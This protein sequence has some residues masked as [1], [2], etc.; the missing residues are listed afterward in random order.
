MGRIYGAWS[1]IGLQFW[2]EE[3]SWEGFVCDIS[4]GSSSVPPPLAVGSGEFT[5]PSPRV[6]VAGPSS[7]PPP[8][9]VGSGQSTPSPPTVAGMYI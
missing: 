3:Q 5:P 4:S 2:E 6:P 7:V 9:A 1:M 8:L